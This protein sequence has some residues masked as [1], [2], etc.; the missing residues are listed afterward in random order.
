MTPLTP[1]QTYCM[2]RLNW[3]Y[4]FSWRLAVVAAWLGIVVVSSGMTP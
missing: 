4:V 1:W 2:E 3:R